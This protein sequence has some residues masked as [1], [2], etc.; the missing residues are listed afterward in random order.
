MET[1][2][3]LIEALSAVCESVNK[4]L[5]AKGAEYDYNHE[6]TDALHALRSGESKPELRR[7]FSPIDEAFLR[8]GERMSGYVGAGIVSREQAVRLEEAMGRYF[9][10]THSA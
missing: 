8:R 2:N 6:L 7:R 5:E 10:D 1:R 9:R 3:E 4:D